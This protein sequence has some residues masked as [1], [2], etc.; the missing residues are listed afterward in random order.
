MNDARSVRD[1]SAVSRGPEVSRARE[2]SD[3]AS[4]AADLSAE[5][6]A[7]EERL[8]RKESLEELISR[9]RQN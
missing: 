3:C 1:A 9:D 6:Y 2:C 7:Q 8:R 5:M 4:R